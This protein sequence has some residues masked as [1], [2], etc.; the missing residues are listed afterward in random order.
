MNSVDYEAFLRC[1]LERFLPEQSKGIFAHTVHDMM[2][3]DGWQ[4]MAGTHSELA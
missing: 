3:K 4:A 2:L 1:F